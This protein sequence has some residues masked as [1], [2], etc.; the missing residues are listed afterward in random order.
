MLGLSRRGAAA[1]ITVR[2]PPSL[3]PESIPSLLC[4]GCSCAAAGAAAGCT[5][6]LLLVAIAAL[7]P[8]APLWRQT[9]R[10]RMYRLAVRHC[11]VPAAHYYR[12]KRRG[13]RSRI[14]LLA[15]DIAD[16]SPRSS[17]AVLL[18]SDAH[19]TPAMRDGWQLRRIAGRRRDDCVRICAA[20]RGAPGHQMAAG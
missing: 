15:L 20:A 10:K 6:L 11:N 8:P 3:P 19:P 2:C 18:I 9:K 4:L 1:N 5:D 17:R 14:A 16:L 7:P 12:P 13:C